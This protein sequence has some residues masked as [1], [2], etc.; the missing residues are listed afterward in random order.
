ME[1]LACKL[2]QSF[3]LKWRQLTVEDRYLDLTGR[4]N[5]SH[6]GG[7]V[8]GYRSGRCAET[9]ANSLIGESVGVT[10]TT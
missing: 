8:A 1:H 6:A 7:A 9:S 2:V 4:N 5:W 10:S 3:D